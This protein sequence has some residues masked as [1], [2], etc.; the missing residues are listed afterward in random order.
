MSRRDSSLPVTPTSPRDGVYLF[1]LEP[2][3][4]ESKEYFETPALENPIIKSKAG[5]NI[6]Q[7]QKHLRKHL[8]SDQD[9]NLEDVICLI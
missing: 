3:T 6:R 1:G 7:L 8:W 9:I 2:A 5:I 4:L